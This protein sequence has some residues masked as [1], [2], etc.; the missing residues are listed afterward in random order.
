M[1]NDKNKSGIEVSFD[2]HQMVNFGGGLS[3]IDGVDVTK[4]ARQVIMYFHKAKFL[5][6][7]VPE[8]NKHTQLLYTEGQARNY[9]AITGTRANLEN[10]KKKTT[11]ILEI[12]DQFLRNHG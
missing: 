3:V 6:P 11:R 1:S 12:Y 5:D 9:V 7:E 4:T 10:V 8:P 2:I